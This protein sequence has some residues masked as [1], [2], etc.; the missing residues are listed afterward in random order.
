MG[1]TKMRA[2]A[3]VDRTDVSLDVSL[4]PRTFG[5]SFSNRVQPVL[6][7]IL[8]KKKICGGYPCEIIVEHSTHG[9]LQRFPIPWA[10]SSKFIAQG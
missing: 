6:G 1:Q 7:N 10:L 2:F 8:G 3:W 5:D 9:F 4:H